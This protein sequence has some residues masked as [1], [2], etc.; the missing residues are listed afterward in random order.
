MTIL[1]TTLLALLFC[2]PSFAASE[3]IAVGRNGSGFVLSQ[4]GKTFTPWGYNYFR[5]ERFRLLEDYWNSDQPDGWRKFERDFRELKRLGANVV[6]IHLQFEKF[7]DSPGKP[8]VQNLARLS[9]VIDLAEE[10]GIYLDITGLGTYRLRD[11]PS[12][13]SNASEKAHWAMQAEFWEAI[14][15][16]CA[17]RPGVFA[18]NLMNE[19]LATSAKQPR[20]QWTNPTALQ[21]Q[22]YVEFINLDPDSRKPPEIA[23][24]WIRQM[25]ASIRKHDP[26]HLITVGM[27]WINNAAPEML[28]GFPP[29]EIAPEVDF[30]A[31][32]VYPETGKVNVALDSL[33]RYQV[34]KPILI[35]ETFPMKCTPEE[36]R[37]F[38]EASRGLAQG[39]LG[40]YWSLSPQDITG[41]SD[42]V[43]GLLRGQFEVLQKLNPSR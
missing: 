37:V 35:E 23:R 7:M 33:R 19:P 24:A 28:S 13:Y 39:W 15:K 10:L 22:T 1:R 4:S 8:N 41:S 17:N 9:K 5:D 34:G 25:T 31:V 6:R 32:H 3:W 21:G 42:I 18:Y 36:W 2:L 27:I 11:V 29:K 20:G 26:R 43:H 14:A 30:L 12:W 16:V 40:Q 38:L